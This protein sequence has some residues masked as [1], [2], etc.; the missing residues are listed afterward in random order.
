MT[1]TSHLVRGATV[2]SRKL[3]WGIVSG[4]MIRQRYGTGGGELGQPDML[5]VARAAKA[6]MCQDCLCTIPKGAL[7]GVTLA[8]GTHYCSAC[9]TTDEPESIFKPGKA[10]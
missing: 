9:V 7:Y 6:H 1:A 2:W 4:D 5:T 3:H 8:G 10:A